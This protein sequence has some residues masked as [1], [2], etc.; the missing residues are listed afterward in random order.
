MKKGVIAGIVLVVIILIGVGVFFFMRNSSPNVREDASLSG[1]EA[2][3]VIDNLDTSNMN[4]LVAYYSHT[5][6][7]EAMA[8]EIAN[9]VNGDLFKIERAAEYNDLYTEAEDEINNGDRPELAD[10][11]DNMDS[12]DVIFIGYP[13]WWD[14][15]PAMINSFLESYDLTDKIVIPFCTSSSDGIENGMASIRASS[16]NAVVLDGL[17]L[18]GSSASSDSGKEEISNWLNSLNI[19]ESAD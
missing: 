9:Q 3:N 2:S 16:E 5:G 19:F 13:I 4:I 14:M 8:E 10:T 11:V 18:S 17:R 15:P 7:T 6:N 12:Y 1:D